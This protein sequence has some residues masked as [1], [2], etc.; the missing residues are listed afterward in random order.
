MGPPRRL[1]SA[2]TTRPARSRPGSPREPD[3]PKSAPRRSSWSRS[4]RPTRTCS[5]QSPAGGQSFA[6]AQPP[7]RSPAPAAL[8]IVKPAEPRKRRSSTAGREQELPVPPS[9]CSRSRSELD[10]QQREEHAERR[11]PPEDPRR[12]RVDVTLGEIHS[13]RHHA[14]NSCRPRRPVEK[15]SGWTRTSPWDAR[16]SVRIWPPSRKP[17]WASSPNQHPTPVG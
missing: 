6:P 7:S 2:F 1:W 4:G 3:A 13:A 11:E 17:P 9:R 15:I 16:Q 14:T 10:R 12:V 8:N 5:W